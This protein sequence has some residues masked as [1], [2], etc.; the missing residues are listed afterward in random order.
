M[1]LRGIAR[2]CTDLGIVVTVEG[3][4]TEEQAQLIAVEPNVREVQGFF[5]CPPLP[6]ERLAQV[7]S[8]TMAATAAAAG[9]RARSA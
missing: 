9:P 2:L 5:F 8:V 7:L 1:L 4:E 3:I 6:A